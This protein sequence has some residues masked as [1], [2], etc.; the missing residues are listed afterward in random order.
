MRRNLGVESKA[1]KGFNWKYVAVA[2]IIVTILVGGGLGFALS[3][4]SS[5]LDNTRNTLTSTQSQLSTTQTQLSSTQSELTTANTNLASTK[6]QLSQAQT[7]LAATQGQLTS[8]QNELSSTKD[9][10]K[11]SQ[12]A[13][14]A[15]NAQLS[16]TQSQLS[17]T[18]SSLSTAQSQLTALNNKY[19]S[20][21]FTSMTQY[22]SFINTIPTAISNWDGGI[23]MSVQ[24]QA[25]AEQNGYLWSVCTDYTKNHFYEEVTIG[26]TQ[27]QINYL[28]QLNLMWVF[29]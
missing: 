1:N 19:P 24:R 10:L 15:A 9:D 16:S 23:A 11:T 18:Q 7:T 8:T 17:A 3:S 22:L 25:F 6:D 21:N 14:T 27:Y 12:A 13:L 28:G 2:L 29:N 20:K 26:N 4:T 5:K